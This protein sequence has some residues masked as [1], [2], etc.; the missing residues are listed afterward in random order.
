[1]PYIDTRTGTGTGSRGPAGPVSTLA[2]PA[3]TANRKALMR[4][5][6]R[7]LQNLQAQPNVALRILWVADDPRSSAKD[8]G[9]L[10]ETDQALT[11]KVMQMANSAFYGL[12]NR[13]SSAAMAVTVLGFSSV[14]AMA[15]TSASGVLADSA[16][17]PPAFWEHAATTATAAAL[18]ADRLGANRNDAFSIGMLHDLG[19]AL[20]W[21]VDADAYRRLAER[22]A[23]G[24]QTLA[25][26]EMEMF[27]LRHE[28]AI[29]EILN[30]WR[31]PDEFVDTLRVHH[32]P[33]GPVSRPLRSALV[34]AEDLCHLLDTP[35][36]MHDPER[37][38]GTLQALA[39]PD[40]ALARLKETVVRDAADLATALATPPPG[41]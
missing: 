31:F 13:V 38:T 15:A 36:A 34:A 5:L 33:A 20:L 37:A 25:E 41:R 9:A 18:L 28:E 27:G 30:S 8:L 1:M 22:V 26:A 10:V 11:V 29:A 32:R 24:E 17:T 2:R 39:L 40:D 12:S 6:V 16:N 14:R 7:E 19:Q 35:P 21:R 4:K 3:P 23:G